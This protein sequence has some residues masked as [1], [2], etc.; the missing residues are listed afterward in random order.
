VPSSEVKQRLAD[1][2]ALWQADGII[3]EDTRRK[4]QARYDTPGFGFV[5][6]VKYLGITGGMLAAMGLLG[7]VAAIAESQATAGIMLAGVS[8]FLAWAG[9]RLGR[10]ARARY[11]H[12]SKI[13]L[14]L[15][16]LG[17][18][19]AVGVEA[20]ALKMQSSQIAFVV[21]LGVV[22]LAMVIAYRE[23][24]GFLL[25]LAV[26]GIFHW[27]GSWNRMFG[28]STYEFE[29]DEPRIMAPVA[30]AVFLF[31]LLRKGPGRFQLVYQ[32]VALIYFNLSLLILSIYPNSTAV[33]Y[34]VVLTAAAL[35]QIFL[36]ARLKSALVM[37]FGVTMLG[38]DL[39]TRYFEHMWDHLSGGLFFLVGGILLMAFGAA[40][41]RAYR[42]WAQ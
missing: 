24:N 14:M 5:T 3:D 27:V 22:P 35:G 42:R 39:F 40:F 18:A 31:G 26:L 10:D 6:A 33:I 23:R 19:G 4:L 29:I 11:E 1:D 36:G 32:T 25:T 8:G 37:G 9:L 41:E 34:M 38:V 2:V 17:W 7:L 20:D 15:G 21:G 28:R 30:V 12:S 13:V 16:V